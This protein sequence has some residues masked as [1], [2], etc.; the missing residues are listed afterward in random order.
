MWSQALSV[1]EFNSGHTLFSQGEGATDLY[2]VLDGVWQ[3]CSQALILGAAGQVQLHRDPNRAAGS[4]RRNSTEPVNSGPAP[5]TEWIH[6]KTLVIKLI[7]ML[8]GVSKVNGEIQQMVQQ[9]Q[10]HSS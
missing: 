8:K 7:D 2:I 5:L 4:K 6:V 3:C 1:Q 10:L 9:W